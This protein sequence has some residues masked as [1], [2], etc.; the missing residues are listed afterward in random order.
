MARGR[1]ANRTH[2]KGG[3]SN[4]GLRDAL[5]GIGGEK[6]ILATGMMGFVNYVTRNYTMLQRMYRSNIWVKKAVA[7]PADYAVKGWR[8][9]END[10]VAKEEKRLNLKAVTSEAIKWANLFGGSLAVMIVDDGQAP[11]MPLDLNKIKPNGFKR[12]VVVDRWKTT[13]SQINTNP[14][15]DNYLEPEY[16]LVTV[17]NHTAR[18]HP[19]RCH[20]FITNSLPHDEAV[21]EQYWGVSQIEIIYRQLIADDTFLSSVAN[22][23]KKATVDIMGIPNLANMIKNGQEEAVKERIRIAQ[24]AMSTLNTWV[25][26]AG[27]NGQN[28]ET[29]ER[30]TQHFSGFDAM[31]IQSLKRIAAAAEIPATIFLGQSPDGMNATGDS[32][33]SIFSDR[34]TAIREIN[35][36][37]FLYKVDKIIAISNGYEVSEYEWVNPFPKSEKE[38][39]EIRQINT[40]MLANMQTMQVSDRVIANRMVKYGLID[41]DQEQEVAQGFELESF[42]IEGEEN[43]NDY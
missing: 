29:Y 28:S 22:M 36:D 33:L 26:D 10:E 17:G 25:K 19:S 18:Y 35:I 30:I 23:M 27:Y 2:A 11:D 34:L 15:E 9:C 32:D 37:P 41:S 13:Y 21:N 40:N 7:I 16:Y 43:G 1:R 24:S 14:F 3:L 38:D 6:D 8:K 5:S 20:K 4:D 39:A 31:D 42:E 12:I